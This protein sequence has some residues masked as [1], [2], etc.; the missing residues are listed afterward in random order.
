MDREERVRSPREQ[1]RARGLREAVE[2]R[3]VRLST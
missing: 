2:K 1:D 3:E